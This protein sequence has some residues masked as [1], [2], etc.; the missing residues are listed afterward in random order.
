MHITNK[1]ETLKITILLVQWASKLQKKKTQEKKRHFI[2]GAA[3][4]KNGRL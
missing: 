3:W 2:K 4:A 1:R